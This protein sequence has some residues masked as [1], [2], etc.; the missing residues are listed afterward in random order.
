MLNKYHFFGTQPQRKDR[1]WKRARTKTQLYFI[2]LLLVHKPRLIR[3]GETCT[4]L[5][6]EQII[7]ST[8]LLNSAFCKFPTAHSGKVVETWDHVDAFSLSGPDLWPQQT[9]IDL[10][11]MN[12]FQT[13]GVRKGRGALTVFSGLSPIIIACF[14]LE[15]LRHTL[16]WH[17]R[18]FFIS[19]CM[20]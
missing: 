8:N 18:G 15:P 10:F 6:N 11:S 13:P 14:Y 3:P 20:G 4:I 12:M 2:N 19:Q 9:W 5:K 7:K 17:T 1:L 16:N